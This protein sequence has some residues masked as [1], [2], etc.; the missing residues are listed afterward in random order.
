MRKCN[1]QEKTEMNM[2]T[3]YLNLIILLYLFQHFSVKARETS[4][5][6]Q[7]VML[8]IHKEHLM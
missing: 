6:L 1:I 8:T 2:K 4:C 3:K 5:N 7:S